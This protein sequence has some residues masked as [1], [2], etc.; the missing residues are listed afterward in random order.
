MADRARGRFH[1]MYFK[2]RVQRT[3]TKKA[4][5]E[6]LAKETYLKED[7]IKV[8]LQSFSALDEN[9]DGK[10]SKQEIARAYKLA[11]FKPTKTDLDEIVVEHDENDDG[12][13][14]FAEFFKAMRVKMITNDFE[15]ER[16]KTAF[17]VLDTNQ[18]G[19]IARDELRHAISTSG[20]PLTE[21]EIDS[22]IKRADKNHDGKIDFNEYVE[23]GLDKCIF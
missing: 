10:I 9:G 8:I 15:E 6:C 21:K 5:T 20:D 7:Q 2:F 16:L 13:I 3:F 4:D 11:G 17:R 22:L 14:D 23:A 1:S 19:F 12:Y 18:D